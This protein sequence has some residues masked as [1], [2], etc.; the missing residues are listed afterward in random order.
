MRKFFYFL[1]FISSLFSA[2]I[3][4]LFDEKVLAGGQYDIVHT[5]CANIPHNSKMIYEIKADKEFDYN[6]FNIKECVWNG[7]VYECN[8]SL[9]AGVQNITHQLNIS[10]F[11]NVKNLEVLIRLI[12]ND[13][14]YGVC[15]AQN[16]PSNTK[17]GGSGG[18]S[19]N[20][21]SPLLVKEVEIELEEEKDLEEE[22]E[23][24][25]EQEEQQPI[26]LPEETPKQKD[27][28][29]N[30]TQN[31]NKL[32]ELNKE[33]I[34]LSNDEE[35]L[36]IINILVFSTIVIVVGGAVVFGIGSMFS[37][38]IAEFFSEIEIP[39]KK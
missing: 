37:N 16:K 24:D 32:K 8:L 17:S 3:T 13:E 14:E 7:T 4:T 20:S 19:T 31:N 26:E 27:K 5:V 15:N 38:T 21:N 36:N 28:E 34:I 30:Q 1:F 25:Q 6:D 39:K 29:N 18:G 22:Q 10:D 12:G 11:T 23:T 9:N 35:E 33:N 2:T